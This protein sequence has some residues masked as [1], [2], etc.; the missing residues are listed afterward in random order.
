[1]KANE[2]RA[3][4]Q[5]DLAAKRKAIETVRADV[6]AMKV[7]AAALKEKQE[8]ALAYQVQREEQV[9]PIDS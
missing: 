7:R 6:T 9:K 8:S 5:D 4:S 3:L 1:M 2:L